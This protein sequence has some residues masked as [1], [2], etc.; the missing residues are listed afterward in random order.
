MKKRT[1]FGHLGG[2]HVD[3]THDHKPLRSLGGTRSHKAAFLRGP[4]DVLQGS[5]DS[6]EGGVVKES[7][8]NFKHYVACLIRGNNS[9]EAPAIKGGV[10]SFK[11]W[12]TFSS[13]T[14]LN[15]L[16]RVTRGGASER[17]EANMN[18][19]ARRQDLIHLAREDMESLRER[20]ASEAIFG[21]SVGDRRLTNLKYILP[22]LSMHFNVRKKMLVSW[23]ILV[24]R[25]QSWWG[26]NGVECRELSMCE[27]VG[28]R[29]CQIWVMTGVKVRTC[30]TIR[31]E[32]SHGTS[33]SK[34]ELLELVYVAI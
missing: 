19:V 15:K 11:D 33:L 4:A 10:D 2:Q 3:F 8:F 14:L 20:V 34:L 18:R 27:V 31:F 13:F 7:F 29:S 26:G 21:G 6:E 9:A 25:S 12:A 5:S 17:R 24:E 30:P 23:D 28:L 16:D 32:S 1:P 22:V